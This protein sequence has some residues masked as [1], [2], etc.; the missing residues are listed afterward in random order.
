MSIRYNRKKV[1]VVNV[2]TPHER[3]EK[4]EVVSICENCP[5][6]DCIYHWDKGCEHFSKEMEKLKEVAK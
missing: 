1:K 3:Y 6:P 5:Y 2:V 4:K